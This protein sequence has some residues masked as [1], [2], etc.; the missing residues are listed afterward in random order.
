MNLFKLSRI[1]FSGIILLV[2]TTEANAQRCTGRFVNPIS[3]ICWE[4]LFPITIGSFEIVGG[5]NPDTE[6]PDIPVCMC[7]G[8]IIGLTQIGIAG[9]FWEPARLVDVTKRP[10]CFP[11][12]GGLK[13]DVGI[14]VGTGD[15]SRSSGKGGGSWHVHWYIY[16]LIYWL[17]LLTDFACLEQLNFDVAYIT[18][19]DPLWQDDALTFILNPEAILFGN[20]IAQA[21]C[22]ADC[23]AA[24]TGLPMDSLFW[25]GGCQGGMYPLNGRIQAHIGSVQSGLLAV[26]RMTYKLHRELIAWGT[27]GSSNEEICAKY[28]MPIMKKSQYRAQLVVPVPSDCYPFGRTTTIYE[29]GKE[30]PI[31]GEDFGFLVWRKRNCCIL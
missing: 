25:C 2:M 17:E 13:L 23:A 28:P 10:Y 18:E 16:P 12:L 22:M 11:S 4:C 9:G 8:K 27:S 21:A 24:T 19:L 20:S 31:T 15:A 14:K 6:N 1:V 29:S 5:D 30:I 3:D 7:P 26:E